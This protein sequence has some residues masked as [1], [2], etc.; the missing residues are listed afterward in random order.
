MGQNT[1]NMLRYY[2]D[3]NSSPTPDHSTQNTSYK[4]TFTL[5]HPQVFVRELQEK[6]VRK[7]EWHGGEDRRQFYIDQWRAHQE[8]RVLVLVASLRDFPIAQVAIHWNGK[9]TFP[10]IPDIQSLR[11]VEALRGQ[12]V[13]TQLLKACEV[14]VRARKYPSVGISVALDNPNAQRLYERFGFHVVGEPYHDKWSYIDAKGDPVY[15]DELVTDLIMEL[16]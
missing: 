12:G 2:G 14:A 5:S 3:M 13:G 16:Q 7:L 8:K 9:P 1:Y 11:T 15:V 6:D 4:S 10:N